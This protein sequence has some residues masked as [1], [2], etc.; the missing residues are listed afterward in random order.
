MVDSLFQLTVFA[1]ITCWIV[2]V[3]LPLPHPFC[4]HAKQGEVLFSHL[5]A[6]LNIGTI[7]GADSHGTIQ[8]SDSFIFTVPEVS[9]SAVDICSDKSAA[10]TISIAI[11]TS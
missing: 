5:L 7:E 10:G 8:F 6:N 4:R 1:V 11:L 9:M 2:A 3:A